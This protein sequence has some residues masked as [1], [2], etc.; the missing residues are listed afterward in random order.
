MSSPQSQQ[1]APPSDGVNGASQ[2]HLENG[3]EELKRPS[4]SYADTDTGVNN[5]STTENRPQ[6]LKC[7]SS[8]LIE[9]MERETLRQIELAWKAQRSLALLCAGEKRSEED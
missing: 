2:G 8:H 6:D 4:D 3:E 1:N 5:D 9:M 7:S